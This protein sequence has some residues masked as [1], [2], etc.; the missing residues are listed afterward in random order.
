[1][2]INNALTTQSFTRAIQG[3]NP[4]FLLID[5]NGAVSNARTGALT[6]L[7][8]GNSVPLNS[9]RGD[10]TA[11]RLAVGID[12]Q[13][14]LSD[15]VNPA[16][17][18]ATTF[19]CVDSATQ[20]A[21]EDVYL[22]SNSLK[23]VPT[24]ASA[25]GF[26]AN[27]TFLDVAPPNAATDFT[28]AMSASSSSVFFTRACN[29]V[30]AC[31]AMLT[32]VDI[33][34]SGPANLVNVGCFTAIG[35]VTEA[36]SNWSGTATSVAGVIA[37]GANLTHTTGGGSITKCTGVLVNAPKN[38]GASGSIGTCVGVSVSPVNNASTTANIGVQIALQS[39][40]PA[41]YA[42]YIPSNVAGT[43][44]GIVFGTAADTSFWRGA[45]NQLLTPGDWS[46][47]HYL[48][49]SVPTVAL[50]P[51]AGTGGSAGVTISPANDHGFVVT[52]VTGNAGTPTAND[53]LFTVTFGNTWFPA[54]SFTCS[55]FNSATTA[56]LSGT[57]MPF[58]DS[59]NPTTLVF[60]SNS[61]ALA[62]GTTYKFSFVGH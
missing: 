58:I 3:T 1:M 59:V 23:L 16:T 30:Q 49:S 50:G 5:D 21:S 12:T 53:T 17:P 62:A 24:E 43:G 8:V 15:A 46:A 19:N 37:Q 7:S 31:R 45:A 35:L 54:P 40:A 33:V 56:A 41:N 26:Q 44:A 61:A 48:C 36:A 39:N 14:N 2:A 10:V 28:A 27:R 57:S 25:A 38:S 32:S 6:S 9:A 4:T 55:P 13:F 22:S 52:L 11:K 20:T 60:K 18:S 42:L 29:T 51:A 47:R 34:N